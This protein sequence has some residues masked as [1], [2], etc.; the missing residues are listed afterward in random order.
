MP[1]ASCGARTRFSVQTAINA[2]GTTLP[3]LK[4]VHCAYQDQFERIFAQNGITASEDKLP[5]LAQLWDTGGDVN[6][7]LTK[8]GQP[9]K[10]SITELLSQIDT[11][12]PAKNNCG[13]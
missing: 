11:T 3:H 13:I 8:N 6:G 5:L 9:F 2:V 12:K 10:F 4:Y 1:C 7:T